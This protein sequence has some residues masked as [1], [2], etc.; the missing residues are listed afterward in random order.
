MKRLSLFLSILTTTTTLYAANISD[1]DIGDGMYLQGV[2]SDE[3]VYVVRI[4]YGRNRVKVRRSEDGTTKWVNASNLISR[5]SSTGNDILRGAVVVSALA[6]ALNPERCK[7]NSSNKRSSSSYSSRSKTTSSSSIAA[8]R[9]KITNK[10][11]YM[12]NFAMHYKDTSGRWSSVGWW[13]INPNRYRYLNFQDGTYA[14]SNNAT[15]YYYAESKQQGLIWSGNGS[16]IYNVNG[17]NLNMKKIRDT[18]GDS[19]LSLSCS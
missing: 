3:L 15:F 5:E 16:H 4:D 17:R 1:L 14:K 9:F 12:V 19:E 18:S 7:G 11:Q 8:H 2:F 6:C 13:N 10:C